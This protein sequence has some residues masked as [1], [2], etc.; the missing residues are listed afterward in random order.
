MHV[1]RHRALLVIE[2]E[3]FDVLSCVAAKPCILLVVPVGCL[4]L[5]EGG[6]RITISSESV[7]PTTTS[8]MVDPI[9]MKYL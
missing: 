9:D 7:I 2:Y 6:A 3:A 1:F 8:I 5:V 4:I